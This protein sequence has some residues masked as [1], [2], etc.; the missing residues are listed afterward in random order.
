MRQIHKPV[1]H[2]QVDPH[3]LHRAAE[4]LLGLVLHNHRN[5]GCSTF[6]FVDTAL[7]AYAIAE[8]RPVALVWADVHFGWLVGRY[9]PP[10]R[11]RV[12]EFLSPT[13]AGLVEDLACHLQDLGVVA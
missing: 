2:C 3:D 7:N 5:Q 10:G 9:D 12:D 8:E 1:A 11:G 6:V 4:R 13:I